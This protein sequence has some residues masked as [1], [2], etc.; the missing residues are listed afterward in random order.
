MYSGHGSYTIDRNGDEKDARDE[1]IIPLDMHGIVDDELKQIIQT[2]LKTNVTLFALFDSCFSGSVLDLRYQYLDSLNY[3]SFT[4]N[5]KQLDTQGNV[6]M[7]SGCSDQ[8]TSADA[9]ISGRFNGAMTWSFLECATPDICWRDLL[10]NMRKALKASSFSQ[11]PQ[12]SSG[13]IVNI[14]HKVFLQTI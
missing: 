14:D 2:N 9:S 6:I 1:M 10:K 3:E 8:Q 5:N 13:S 11:L 12:M 4:E 7:I